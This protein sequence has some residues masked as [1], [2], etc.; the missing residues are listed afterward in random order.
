MSLRPGGM[1][2]GGL[3]LGPNLG[4]KA[5]KD[6]NNKADNEVSSPF[7]GLALGAKGNVKRGSGN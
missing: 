2:L 6:N 5:N 1:D 4:N 7:A 3:T